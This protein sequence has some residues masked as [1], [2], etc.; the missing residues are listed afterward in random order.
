MPKAHYLGSQAEL[1]DR[2][3]VKLVAQYG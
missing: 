1:A 3:I 2:A